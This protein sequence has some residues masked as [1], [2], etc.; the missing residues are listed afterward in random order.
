[1]I[2]KIVNNKL[3]LGVVAFINNILIDS[4]TTEEHE[5]LIKEQLSFL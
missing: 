3:D 2:N 4:Q 1:M 5:N